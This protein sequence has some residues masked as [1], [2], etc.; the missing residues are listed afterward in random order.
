[1]ATY[2][3]QGNGSWSTLTN[4]D[5]NAGGGGSDPASVAAMDNNTFI[6]QAAHLIE[7]DVDISG[8]AN[9]IAGLTI[10]GGASPGKL[11]CKHSGDGTYWLMIKTGTTLAG[12]TSTNRGRLL[13]NS[14]GTWG[15]T[16]ALPFG[17]KFTID[18]KGTAKIDASNLDIQLYDTEP[19]FSSVATYG[20][21]I[22]VSS[23]N[24]GTDV[25]TLGSAHG[26]STNTPVCVQSSATL[27]SPLVADRV[28][29][30]ISPSGADLKLAYY[31]SGTA[32][33][34]TDSGSGTV[35]VYS[36]HTNTSTDTLNVL[37]D[38][39]TDAQWASGAAVVLVNTNAPESY[40][41]QRVT[42][43]TVAS[44]TIQLSA[45]VDSVQYP[46][47]RI[48]LV[49]RHVR[50]LSNGT[51]GTQ[52]IVDYGASTFTGSVLRC[53]IRNTSGTGTMFYGYGISGGYSHTISGAVSGCSN[54]VNYGTGHTISGA[55][56]GCYSG[57][58]YGT[59]HTISGAVG[60]TLLGA[61]E[62]NIYDFQLSTADG[63]LWTSLGSKLPSPP[64]FSGRTAAIS[65]G[66][67]LYCEDYGQ[68]VGASYAFQAN[69]DVIKNT[70]T[71]RTG[72][73]SSSL[74]VI[75]LSHCSVY[76]GE[77]IALEWTE[78]DVAASA[79]VRSVFML[80]YGW[81]GNY[82]TNTELYFEAEYLSAGSGTAK[83]V[84]KSTQVLTDNTT[85]TEFSVSFTPSQ[86]GLVRYRA[87]LK[88]YA[89]SCKV[90]IDNQLN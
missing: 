49:A 66:I 11:Y 80:G 12:T 16:G 79:Q 32:I 34:I 62:A 29:Y 25:I 45:N 8:F 42:L 3:S 18:L 55:V 28:Y 54:G 71:V 57:V 19:T 82:P 48:V 59:G 87:Y 24:T 22:A 7:F 86:A 23:I 65:G 90:F 43:G 85:W 36:G 21:K 30:V 41:Q 89:A 1:M 27:P 15:N 81:S 38:V 52:P 76:G 14:D 88:K 78:L 20:T 50:I 13:A 47:A 4:W 68:T 72:G 63:G 70:T 77:I 9:G 69:G 10:T 26:W 60:F 73:A 84:V 46:G 61:T 39:T 6:I 74:E 17:R 2:Y 5:T 37:T 35:E 33:N 58:N 51:S 56:S 44:G 83:T 67:G 75:P 64:V 53:G 40:D 31:S